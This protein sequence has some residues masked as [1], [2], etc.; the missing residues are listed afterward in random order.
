MATY[1]TNILYARTD[2]KHDLDRI[3]VFGMRISTAISIGKVILL[4]LNFSPVGNIRKRR[5]PS[6]FLLWKTEIIDII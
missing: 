6:C 5:L 3:E 2:N 1:A 4:M